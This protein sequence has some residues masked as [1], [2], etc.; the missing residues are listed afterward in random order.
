MKLPTDISCGTSISVNGGTRQLV[1]FIPTGSFSAVGTMTIP[2]Q[3]A[4]GSNT[5]EFADPAA[6]APDFDRIIVADAPS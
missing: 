3:L 2:L 4:V 5:I 6:Y 1:S